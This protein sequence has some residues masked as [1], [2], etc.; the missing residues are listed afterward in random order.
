[1]KT[2]FFFF[3]LSAISGFVQAASDSDAHADWEIRPGPGLPSLEAVGLS[4][5]ILYN[6]SLEEIANPGTHLKFRAISR[7]ESPLLSKRFEPFCIPDIMPAEASCAAW[8]ILYLNNLGTTPCVATT[9]L[10]FFVQCQKSGSTGA[11][12]YGWVAPGVYK[13]SVSSACRDVARG[14]SWVQNNPACYSSNKCGSFTCL[15]G[16]NAAY[17]NGEMAVK[18]RAWST[19]IQYF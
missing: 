9:G 13:E 2:S 3:A 1:M 16:V 11:T 14:I 12:I 19:D 17:G 15:G 5:E 18:L 8:C 6:M 7:I 10:P 4:K